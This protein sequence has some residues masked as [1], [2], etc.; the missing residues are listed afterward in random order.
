MDDDVDVTVEAP[1]RQTP[2]PH[3]LFMGLWYQAASQG[4]QGP[5][6]IVH[7]A[8]AWVRCCELAGRLE[9]M[10]RNAAEAKA[11][12]PESWPPARG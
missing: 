7:W 3:D 1:V 8:R 10:E 9:E 2:S 5:S 11:N 4:G 6:A 12:T